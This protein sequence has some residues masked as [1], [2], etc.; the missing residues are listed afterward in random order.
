[1]GDER[2]FL[3]AVT[4]N[5][6]TPY[7]LPRRSEIEGIAQKVYQLI[8]TR[9][10]LSSE[11]G[12]QYKRR[13]SEADA[14]YIKEASRLSGI[15]LGPVVNQLGAKRLLIVSQG[16]LH[17]IP[18]EALPTPS[19]LDTE[20]EAHPLIVDHEIAYL[21][22]AS[23]LALLRREAANHKPPSKAIAVFA[24]P[25]FDRNDPRVP[26]SEAISHPSSEIEDDQPLPRLPTSRWEA[27]EIMQSSPVGGSMAALDFAANRKMAMSGRLEDYRIIHFATH[28]VINN[29]HPELSGVVLSL[30]DERGQ[31]QDGL[32]RLSDIYNMRLSADLVVL[33]ACETGLGKAVKGE[34]VIGFTQSF[35]YAGAQSVMASLWK[36]DD[37]ATADLMARF[38]RGMLRDGLKPAAALREAKLEMWRH[39]GWQH[40]Y[41]WAA[42]ILEG[43][44]ERNV[45]LP[46]KPEKKIPYLYCVILLPIGISFMGIRLYRRHNK[47]SKSSKNWI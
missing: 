25:V 37:R 21:P 10:P 15:L 40:P 34:G 24:D 5:S 42:F 38:Y 43:E 9:K 28:G 27:E 35:M 33:S 1:M 6:I 44:S 31:L 7:E 16:A 14:N 12:A 17:Y 18:F 4:T 39:V 30:V 46:A 29:E 19:A 20:G 23:A 36:V 26:I 8:T 41:Y 2:S 3:W 47:T 11:D 22:S 13:V 45:P 32:L